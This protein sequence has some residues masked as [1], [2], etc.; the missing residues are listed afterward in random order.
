MTHKDELAL[1]FRRGYYLATANI[2]TLHGADVAAQDVLKAY[3]AVDFDGIDPYDRAK[4][5]PIADELNRKA[6]L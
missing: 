4:L 5:Q 6:A 2:L 1:E 3:G